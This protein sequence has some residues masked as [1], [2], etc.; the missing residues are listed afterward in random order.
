MGSCLNSQ[1]KGV[2]LLVFSEMG[3]WNGFTQ[4]F[5]QSNLIKVTVKKI[6]T[7][8]NHIPGSYLTLIKYFKISVIHMQHTGFSLPVLPVRRT[9]YKMQIFSGCKN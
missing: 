5:L 2:T 6:T 3:Y 9:A 4:L 7:K 8:Q 1:R